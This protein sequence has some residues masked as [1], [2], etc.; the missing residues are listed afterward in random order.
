MMLELWIAFIHSFRTLIEDFRSKVADRTLD[1]ALIVEIDS[2]I[3]QRREINVPAEVLN[4]MQN[5]QNLIIANVNAYYNL[6][7]SL[8]VRYGQLFYKEFK[9]NNS[10]LYVRIPRGESQIMEE[11]EW[12]RDIKLTFAQPAALEHGNNIL[13]AI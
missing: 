6:H 12:I 2:Q 9:K 13:L 11:Y 8:P 10:Q 5:N 1:S 3:Q 4:Y 7:K